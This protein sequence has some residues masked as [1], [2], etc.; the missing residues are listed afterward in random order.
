MFSE[1]LMKELGK[2]EKA[3]RMANAILKEVKKGVGVIGGTKRKNDRRI[4]RE[5]DRTLLNKNGLCYLHRAR[6]I[7]PVEIEEYDIPYRASPE[8]IKKIMPEVSYISG[9]SI[10]NPVARLLMHD[11]SLERINEVTLE[12]IV[13]NAR[14]PIVVDILWSEKERYWQQK[15]EDF[16]VS[17]DRPHWILK[18]V[19][20]DSP[21]ITK[22]KDGKAKELSSLK[23]K[24]YLSKIFVPEATGVEWVVDYGILAFLPNP[25]TSKKVAVVGGSHWLST[26][27]LNAM[28]Y[29]V[30][31]I[32][33]MNTE[34]E[35]S[36][37][38]M[39]W[40][41][42]A[43]WSKVEFFEAIFRVTDNFG[44]KRKIS[45]DPIGLFVLD[46]RS[47]MEKDS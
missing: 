13:K 10:A 14:V 4:I 27:A 35:G 26:F 25:V 2:K 47:I 39:I 43:V 20:L 29:L 37:D 46:P 16:R 36:V 42:D 31:R 5:S 18:I 23:K 11:F 19:D 12:E 34:I 8:M 28:L 7:N 32:P 38:S 6:G 44:R 3:A 9:L 45:I 21:W 33:E 30:E 41:F 15:V 17:L 24:K 40:L 22:G 1:K